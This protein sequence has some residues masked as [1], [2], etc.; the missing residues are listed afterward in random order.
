MGGATARLAQPVKWIAERGEEF[1]SSAQGRDNHNRRSGARQTR[2]DEAAQRQALRQDLAH[3]RRQPVRAITAARPIVLSNKTADRDAR[4]LIEQRPDR[5]PDR[6]P[7]VLEI[8]VDAVRASSRELG[9]ENG[10]TVIDR[11]RPLMHE[12]A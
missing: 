11:R 10:G 4:V 3:R 8:D 12:R 6:S 9:G 5:L 7:D 2:S 1:I